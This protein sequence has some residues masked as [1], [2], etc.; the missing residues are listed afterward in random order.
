M[1]QPKTELRDGRVIS[2]EALIRWNHP[3]LG[4]VPPDEFVPI[5]EHSGLITP[6]TLFVLHTALAQR[7]A[8]RRNG[9]D[10][11]VAVNISPRSLTDP[12]FVDEVT[13]ALSGVGAPPD[14][15]T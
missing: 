4:F 14:A 7:E 1:Y 9:Y 13:R 10:I 12:S 2:A 11:G 3:K 6:L 5:A 8:W 15:L